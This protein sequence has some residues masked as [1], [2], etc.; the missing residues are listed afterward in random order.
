MRL[1]RITSY[2]RVSPC[3]SGRYLF[4]ITTIKQI[5][6]YFCYA[7]AISIRENKKLAKAK[8]TT[9]KKKTLKYRGKAEG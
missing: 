5:K 3:S 4:K 2:A 6:T 8:T 1:L 7:L 9:K